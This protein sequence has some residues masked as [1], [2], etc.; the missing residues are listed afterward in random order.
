MNSMTHNAL[1][2]GKHA[3]PPVS[4]DISD[5]LL[6][7][8]VF[9]AG[10][11]PLEEHVAK[12]PLGP[13]AS[14]ADAAAQFVAGTSIHAARKLEQVV[15][16]VT[17]VSS[18]QPAPLSDHCAK[19]ARFYADAAPL[20]MLMAGLVEFCLFLS[21]MTLAR[22]AAHLVRVARDSGANGI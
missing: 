2:A 6:T 9:A 12:E 4:L 10:A 7:G 14:Y 20:V 21:A 1:P 5:V 11:L 13:D 17:R 3:T 18:F 15:A 8:K 22:R 19:V 16:V